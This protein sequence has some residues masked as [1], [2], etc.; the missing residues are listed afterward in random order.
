MIPHA[1]SELLSN[2]AGAQTPALNVFSAWP[3]PQ[4]F[5]SDGES[6][7]WR[8]FTQAVLSTVL[9]RELSVWPVAGGGH[10]PLKDVFIFSHDSDVEVAKALGRIGLKVCGPVPQ[11]LFDLVATTPGWSQRNLTPENASAVLRVCGSHPAA[12]SMD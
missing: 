4:L 12:L 1:W 6:T 7:L 8:T 11:F 3:D 2:I 5:V 9:E 10:F